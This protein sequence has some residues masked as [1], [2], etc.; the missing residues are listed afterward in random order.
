V[1]RRGFTL[2]E[3]LVA[4][5]I[6]AIAVVGLM[7]GL[8]ASA[9]NAA[10]LRNYDRAVQLAQ[11]RMNELLLDDEMPLGL[12]INGEFEP[13][14]SGGVASG[15]RA[16]A[17]LFETSTPPAPGQLGLDRLEVEVWWM[18]GSQRHTLTLDGYRQRVLKPEDLPPAAVAQ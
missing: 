11:L 8:S 2:L 12:E 15:W 5:A 17:T 14:V 4:T 18:E 13:A 3:M 1:T 7:G 6:M 16:R 10:R 9:H